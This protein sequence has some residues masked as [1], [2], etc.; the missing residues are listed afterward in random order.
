MKILILLSLAYILFA[1]W[2]DCEKGNL[3]TAT[4]CTETDL[5]W[6]FCYSGKACFLDNLKDQYLHL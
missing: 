3:L 5:D 6:D 4:K 2:V 1:Q